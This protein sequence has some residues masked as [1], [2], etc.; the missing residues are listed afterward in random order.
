M[1]FLSKI[2][3]GVLVGILTGSSVIFAQDFEQ[4][5]KE[6]REAAL[7]KVTDSSVVEC[8]YSLVPAY[9]IEVR[10]FLKFLEQNFENK[11]SNSSLVNIA[12]VRYTEYKKDI[13]A[14]FAQLKPN[15]TAATGT[16]LLSNEI[17]TYEICADITDT[18]IKLAKEKMIDHIKTTSA[19]KKT[20]MMLEKYKSINTKLRDVNLMIAQM[21]GMFMEF[22]EKLP[23][24]LQECQ[25]V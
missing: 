2:L 23:G 9:D 10:E 20:A 4:E 14:I 21:Y 6:V 11:S 12:I 5:L 17:K 16:N 25:Q 3:V 24:F 7:K 18:Y 1:K 8:Q 19:Q 22:K 15:V 13:Q